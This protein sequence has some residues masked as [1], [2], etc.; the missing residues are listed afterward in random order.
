MFTKHKKIKDEK[1]KNLE[2]LKTSLQQIDI[3]IQN[4]K[5]QKE[6]NEVTLSNL[7]D[8]KKEK[9]ANKEN[10]TF[11]Q[12]EIN[13][14]DLKISEINNELSKSNKD[15]KNLEQEFNSKQKEIAQFESEISSIDKEIY[16]IQKNIK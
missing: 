3:T 7:H 8:E 13:Y 15:I 5:V 9:I 1:T 16:K 10:S 4:T 11:N 14:I 2:A 12:N 6:K